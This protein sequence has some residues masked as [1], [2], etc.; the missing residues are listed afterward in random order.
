MAS[1]DKECEAKLRAAARY[2]HLEDVITLLDEGTQIDATDKVRNIVVDAVFRHVMTI[3]G[4]F[5]NSPEPDPLT[6][7][8]DSVARRA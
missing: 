7:A 2:G 3:H 8:G 6:K 4:Q 1:S 5:S